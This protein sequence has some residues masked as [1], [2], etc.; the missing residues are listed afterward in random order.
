MKNTTKY[1][2]LLAVLC[3]IGCFVMFH[4]F[5]PYHLLHRE[6]MLLFTYSAEQ[7]VGYLNH[8]AALSCLLGDF[9]T[10]F[11]LDSGMGATVIVCV[12]V[13]LLATAYFTCRKWMNGWL[14]MIVALVLVSYEVLRFCNIIYPLSGTISL[15]GAFALFLAIDTC[16]GKWSFPVMALLGTL[17]CYLCFGYGMFLFVILVMVN[18]HS[19]KKN[20][21]GVVLVPA[22]ALALPVWG[23]NKY[24]MMPADAYTY[25]ATVWLGQPRFEDERLLGLKTEVCK[26]NWDKVNEL[27]FEGT[28]SNIV[29][30]CYNLANA[31]NHKLPE[32]LMNYYQPA[33][34]GMFI[35][36][37][38]ESTYFSTLL[39]G[40]I[41]FHLGD[42][43]MAEHAAILSM[44]FSPDHKN[45]SMVKRMAEINLING[46]EAAA[47]KYL[48]ILSNT[49]YYKQWAADR[50]PGKESAEFKK[51]LTMKRSLLPKEDSL[52]LS[53][54]DISRSLHLLLDANPKNQMALNYLLC[55][56]LLMKDIP[57]FLKDYE[58]YHTGAPN[59]LYSEALMIHL[60]QKRAKG[61][62]VKET[63]IHPSIIKEFNHYNQLYNQ[64]QGNPSALESRYGRTYWFYYHFAK[65][66]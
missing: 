37:D 7:F 26:E 40:E 2:F 49:L 62:E 24:L 35:P 31:K 33:F 66:Q 47:M 27:V 32:R 44:I 52:R 1:F 46:D 23:C 11:L 25:P 55:C 16:S 8:P 51:W 15:I 19:K 63:G 36:I 4:D 53:C 43:T 3:G 13:L 30:A 14:A 57:T 59:R 61:S 65:F 6:Q 38:S 20:Y 29:S 60:F 39:A 18:L 21:L 54:T 56:D 42:M 22:F 28:P 58:R 5:C 50:I 64:S 9:L 45:V 41:W 10:Q 17:L 12:Q 48:R 34:L